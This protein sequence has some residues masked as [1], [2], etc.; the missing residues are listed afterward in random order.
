[1]LK[2]INE[3]YDRAKQILTEHKEGHRQL[4]QLL[5]EKEVIYAE[6]VEKIFGKRPWESRTEELMKENDKLEAEKAAKEKA[7]EPKLEDM[8][9]AVKQ[10]Q[11]EYNKSVAEK[12]DADKKVSDDE[13]SEKKVSDDEASEKKVS[14]DEASEKKVSDNETSDNEATE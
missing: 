11:A 9:D 14:D 8:P 5:F 6:D 3:Q 2:I 7:E 12:E 10:A 4:A 13:A 1:M